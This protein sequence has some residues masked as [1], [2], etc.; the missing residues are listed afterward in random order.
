MTIVTDLDR[1]VPPPKRPAQ[2]YRRWLPSLSF[3]VDALF[4][5]GVVAV[6]VLARPL[7]ARVGESPYQQFLRMQWVLVE[8]GKGLEL[9]PL[10]L[11]LAPVL[12]VAVASLAGAAAAERWLPV[13]VSAALVLILTRFMLRDAALP[14]KLLVGTLAVASPLLY[15]LQRQLDVQ[16]FVLMLAAHLLA[17]RA[18]RAQPSVPRVTLAVGVNMLLSLTTPTALLALLASM[19]YCAAL[20]ERQRELSPAAWR[21]LLWLYIPFSLTGYVLWAAFWVI[22]GSRVATSFFIPERA[23]DPSHLRQV[24]ATLGGEP[25]LLLVVLFG[26]GVVVRLAAPGAAGAAPQREHALGWAMLTFLGFAFGLAGLQTMAR[27]LPV[28]L[29]SITFSLVLLIPALTATML[30]AGPRPPRRADWALALLLVVGAALVLVLVPVRFVVHPETLTGRLPTAS[31]RLVAERQAAAAF[32][33]VDPGGRILLDPRVTA[34]FVREAGIDPRRLITPFDDGFER[35]VTAPPD[36]VRVV[37]V[38]DS[39]D[40]AVAGNYPAARIVTMLPDATMIAEGKTEGAGHALVRVFRRELFR[41]PEHDAPF[42]AGDPAITEQENTIAW[43][44]LNEMKARDGLPVR[45]DGWAYAIDLGNLMV[46]AARRGSITLFRLLADRVERDYLVTKSNDP[47]ALFTIAWRHRPDHPNEASGTTETL[48][49][50]EAYWL[51]GERWN[52]DYYRRLAYL[53]AW[54]YARHQWSNE[55]G[56][57][58]FIRNY[59]NYETKEYATNTYLVDYAPDV[60]RRVAEYMGD[61]QLLAVANAA[62]VFVVA[63]QLPSGLFHEMYQPE[64]STLYANIT[65]FSP[66]GVIQLIDSVEAALGISEL[67]APDRARRTYEFAKQHFL[68]SGVRAIS[69]QYSMDGVMGVGRENAPAVYAYIIRLAVRF[70]DLQFARELI[71]EKLNVDRMYLTAPLPVDQDYNWFFAWTSSLVALR[72][73]QEASLLSPAGP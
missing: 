31:P 52:N 22:A 73:Y 35:L 65:Y 50:V 68:E 48:R 69:N 18:V 72:E 60:L 7:L 47:N 57:G 1:P 6:N 30:R 33:Q 23:S 42:L 2:P 36:D 51:A 44:V 25:M 21:A 64:I 43:A 40:D 20:T 19:V 55:Y 17:L 5:A 15:L 11:P 58:W 34:T 70:G 32:R 27:R 37:V 16:L 61:K 28:Q 38:T 67:Y 53:M 14:V 12:H 63:A 13:A 71:N 46:Y 3:G 49:M 56:E 4:V 41:K 9:D 39:L 10:S 62:A 29:E 45:P 26:L 66:N 8:G 59:Y 54:A 24:L